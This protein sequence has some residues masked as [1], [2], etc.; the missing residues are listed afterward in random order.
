M[1]SSTNKQ[2]SSRSSQGSGREYAA[3]FAKRRILDMLLPGAGIVLDLAEATELVS[4]LEASKELGVSQARTIKEEINAAKRSGVTKMKAD[5]IIRRV[6]CS[7]CGRQGH[8]KR[9]CSR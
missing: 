1:S 7:Q 5:S 8:N 9:T 2:N 4:Y 3:N 6:T